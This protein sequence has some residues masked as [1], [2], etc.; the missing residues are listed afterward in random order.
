[1]HYGKPVVTFNIPGSG[2]NF[3]SLKD[4]TG[5]EV[6]NSDYEKYAEAIK[7]LGNDESLRKKYGDAAKERADS[8]FMFKQFKANIEKIVEDIK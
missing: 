5:L 8:M 3:V 7:Q 1:M 6:P 2:V 4:I